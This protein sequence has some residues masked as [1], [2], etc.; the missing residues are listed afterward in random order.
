MLRQDN[1][2]VP[3][4]DSLTVNSP[5][6]DS[7]VDS[8]SKEGFF[9]S[10]NMDPVDAETRVLVLTVDFAYARTPQKRCLWTVS[11]RSCPAAAKAHVLLKVCDVLPEDG[12]RASWAVTI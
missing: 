1:F 12:I 8:P 7:T 9:D 6:V 5:T 10:A 4:V 11:L 2:T 3:T